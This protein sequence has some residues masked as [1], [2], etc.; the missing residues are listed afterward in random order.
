MKKLLIVL[1]LAGVMAAHAEELDRP[2]GIRFGTRMTLMPYVSFSFTHDSNVDASKHSKAGQSWN[3]NPGATFNYK[4]ENWNLSGALYYQ[5]HAYSSGYS[6]SL[7]NS[8]FGESLSYTWSNSSHGGRGWA[9]M[10]SESYSM[11]SQDDDAMNDGGRGIGRDRQQ[12]T[13]AGTLERRFTDRFHGNVNAS[14]YYLHYDNKV[15]SY[16]PLY[17]WQRWTVGAEMG[18]VVSRWTDFLFSGSYHGYTQENDSSKYFLGPQPK[19][20]DSSRGWSLMG[21]IGTHATERISY[22]IMA[23][24]HEYKYNG[25][26]DGGPTYS[27]SGLWKMSDTWNMMAMAARYYSPSETARGSSMITDSVSWGL[28]HTMLR[29]KLSSTFD[30]AYRHQEHPYN[31]YAINDYRQDVGTARFGLNYTINR[32]LSLFGSIEYQK[33]WYNGAAAFKSRYDYDRW[34]G[35]VGFRLTY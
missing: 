5:Y 7:N 16:A 21:G 9:L 10:I 28:G 22:R 35:T 19:V 18:Y 6:K 4:A 2:G 13:I 14:Y 26:S 20:S 17:G 27:I 12:A 30:L 33:N 11:I 32:Y 23:G 1:A 25:H 24:Y 29:G 3:I 34:R 15:G 8:S 31:T